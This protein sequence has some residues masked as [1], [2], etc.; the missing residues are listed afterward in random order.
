MRV[1]AKL[2]E[3][4]RVEGE[5]RLERGCEGVRLEYAPRDRPIAEATIGDR[6]WCGRAEEP[7]KTVSVSKE[8]IKGCMRKPEATEA[9]V[10]AAGPLESVERGVEAAAK[11]DGVV[12]NP[13]STIQTPPISEVI[14]NRSMRTK[15][16]LQC[17][18]H[19]EMSVVNRV[20]YLEGVG[21]RGRFGG[22]PGHGGINEET[23][24]LKL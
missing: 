2:S 5:S 15:G 23:G 17:A 12:G 7:L 13:K 20:D 4:T 9:N 6:R 19:R 24:P 14:V 3:G 22:G 8:S 16:K 11:G 18:A 21:G 10:E 1:R